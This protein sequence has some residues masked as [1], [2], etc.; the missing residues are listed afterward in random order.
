M[1]LFDEYETCKCQIADLKRDWMSLLDDVSQDPVAFRA[2]YTTAMK[3]ME[4]L[5]L[6]VSVW[7]KSGKPLH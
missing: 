5:E 2:R 3:R 1:K 6:Y 4:K 7:I